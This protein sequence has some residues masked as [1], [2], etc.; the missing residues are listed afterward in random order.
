LYKSNLKT[1]VLYFPQRVIIK[2]KRVHETRV[3]G[4]RPKLQGFHVS[5]GTH[6]STPNKKTNNDEE[7]RKEIYYVSLDTLWEEAKGITQPI[8]SHLWGA[9]DMSFRFKQKKIWGQGVTGTVHVYVDWVSY[10]LS[11]FGRGE[12]VTGFEEALLFLSVTGFEEALL[13]LSLETVSS[14][15]PGNLSS[16][17]PVLFGFQGGCKRNIDTKMEYRHKNGSRGAKLFCCF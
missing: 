11:P 10:H 12:V 7:Q 15:P 3:L 16:I 2:Y 17:S 6:S 9:A 4:P 8:F 5:G 1:V 13:F 14:I